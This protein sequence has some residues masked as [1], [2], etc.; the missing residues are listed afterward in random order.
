M[1]GFNEA[2]R[3]AY[4]FVAVFEALS[5]RLATNLLKSPKL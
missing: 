3:L 1:V 5:C 2:Q 4:G